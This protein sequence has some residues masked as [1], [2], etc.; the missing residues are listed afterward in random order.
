MAERRR[1]TPEEL[2]FI[3]DEE[4]VLRIGDIT[5][6]P[7]P[8]PAMT[9]E[10]PESRLVITHL[11]VKNFKSYAGEQQIGF[12]DKNFTAVVGPN[13]SGKSNVIDAMMFV[14]GRRA[15]NIRAKKMSSLIHKSA[16]YPN[17]TSC[18]VT[19][20]F[21]MIKDKGTDGI[22]KGGT[23]FTISRTISSNEDSYYE[24]NGKVIQY[25]EIK[26]ALKKH[27]I[28][29]DYTRFLIL[30]GEIESISQMKPVGNHEKAGMLDY[31]E[32]IIGSN[33][34][35][36]SI[37]LLKE[38]WNVKN[39]EDKEKRAMLRLVAKERDELR[40]PRN[41]AIEFLRLDNDRVLCENSI[42]LFQRTKA[43][44][45]RESLVGKKKILAD[46]IKSLKT[47]M[48][49]V[50]SSRK[51]F[52]KDLSET[53]KKHSD[54]F[55][56]SE[57]L[58]EEF[59]ELERQDA[60]NLM[61]VKHAK[62][63]I[64]N[65]K[66]NLE[67]C[68]NELSKLNKQTSIFENETEELQKKKEKLETEKAF[69]EKKATEVMGS[70]KQETEVLQ[71]K[72]D[73][74][75]NELK[76]LK[77]NMY[78]IKSE[79]D[80]AQ[81]E[82]N[83]CVS[84]VK[85]EKEKLSTLISNLEK[86]TDLS[87][88]E[89]SLLEKQELRLKQLENEVTSLNGQLSDSKANELSMSQQLRNER[90]KYEEARSTQQTSQN[91]SSLLK[92]LLK[93]KSE[94]RIPGIYGRL[95][96]LG[97][98]DEKYDV[99]ISTA[100]GRLD[101][102]VTDT[103]STAQKCVEFLK[104]YNLGYATFIALD[105]MKK[106]EPYIHQKTMTPENVPRLF[107]LVRV[108]DNSLLPAF[109]FAI[110]TTLVAR[111]LEQATRIGL[112]GRE[113][114][115]VVTLK[116]EVIDLAGTMSGGGGHVARGRMGQTIVE[117]KFTNEDISRM[118][119]SINQ[120][121]NKVSEIRK[122]CL[123]LEDQINQK[124][125][126]ISSL[127]HSIKKLKLHCKAYKEQIEMIS[128]QIEEQKKKISES[129]VDEQ[130][131]SSLEETIK[132]KNKSYKKAVQET[133]DTEEKVTKLQE[134]ILKISKGNLSKAKKNL[135]QLKKKYDDV[136]QA[137]TKSTVNFKQSKTKIKKLDNKI[138]SIT[139]ELETNE[140]ILGTFKEKQST[141]TVKGSEIQ[142]K[143]NSC[144]EELIKL[145][146]KQTNLK[147][148]MESVNEEEHKMKSVEIEHKN[149]MKKLDADESEV[150]A[151]IRSFNS[152][153]EKLK[154]NEIEEEPTK[155]PTL[156]KEEIQQLDMR[157]LES[158]LGVI[159]VKLETMTPNLSAIELYKAK[160]VVYEERLRDVEAI[161]HEKRITKMRYDE[162]R[163]RRLHEFML[164]ISVIAKKLK[165]IYQMLTL[166]GDA[167]IELV[168]ASE[169]F[170]YGV[171]LTI[172]PAKKS[173]KKLEFL[174]G[175]EKTLSSLALVFA[176]HYYRPT[177]FYV[178]DEID[179]ALD[180]RNVAIVG[181]F[182]KERTKNAQF[183]IVSLRNVMNELSDHLLGIYKTNNCTKN[184]SLSR[185]TDW[186]EEEESERN[187]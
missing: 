29:M 120:L 70:L 68:E 172:R 37:A 112:K 131:V 66:R 185:V 163:K 154:L 165:E 86:N 168:D 14:F 129:T 38:A 24:M 170:K 92:G 140:K 143:I 25:K 166:G 5:V 44:E 148:E 61:D 9:S 35:A 2:G 133:A 136:S 53:A 32:D 17:I 36:D 49:K 138:Q 167:E 176:L 30:Q 126:E 33:R 160:N 45:E 156:S 105:Q 64:Q 114:H 42:F 97:A 139:K 184:I 82:L 89:G 47:E 16:K 104:R 178:M 118:S 31:I 132:I 101:N 99:A 8:L 28:D 151:I 43:E 171:E 83:I 26:K 27:G 113:R 23:R 34:F 102:I 20:H 110:G 18:T 21:A 39:S 93:E 6:P 95:G 22:M 100:C 3:E 141:I 145:K 91:S 84:G 48:E 157:S 174:S 65:L 162:L 137:I 187:S 134:E 106:Y 88:R 15:K 186:E 69:E 40:E 11:T 124:I 128:S 146:E 149:E 161:R 81:S 72:K 142:E 76:H 58:K 164:G 127:Q 75:E 52:E 180:V 103:I 111:D 7:A 107:D 116:G 19:V 79:I 46:K 98:I 158:E 109:Y 121:S 63:K 96:D 117:C 125:S 177:P 152:K 41:K 150:K 59:K 85:R 182:L 67:D 60:S 78:D 73:K 13:G 144:Q 115:R 4:G 12:F 130:K 181:Y 119:A 135:D 71:E 108:K 159:Q 90:L 56:K 1:L 183:I 175:G 87:K 55:K 122:L 169:P 10:V 123:S 57:E 155:I 179:A 77:E 50:Q 173:W 94:G 74:I 80:L 51:S 54:I 147:K 62:T 153:I